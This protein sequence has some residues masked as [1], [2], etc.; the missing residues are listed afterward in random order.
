MKRYALELVATLVL[1]MAVLVPSLYGLRFIAVHSI[2]K[3]PVALAPAL[4]I[5]VLLWVIFRSIRQQDELQRLIQ[6]KAVVS[7]FCISGFIF[8]AWGFLQ[9]AGFPALD[10]IWVFPVMGAV[11]GVS[12]AFFRWKYC[13]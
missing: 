12:G 3:Y 8:T 10:A 2:W 13:V 4:P 11:W 5:L 1:Y 6:F 9:N 7:A